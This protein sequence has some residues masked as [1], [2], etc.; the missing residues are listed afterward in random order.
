MLSNPS[1]I[2]VSTAWVL[3]WILHSIQPTSQLL[4]IPITISPWSLPLQFSIS[5][6]TGV[7]QNNGKLDTRGPVSELS[8]TYV[9][10]RWFIL[11]CRVK[12][13]FLLCWDVPSS[14]F[15]SFTIVLKMSWFRIFIIPNIFVSFVSFSVPS[16]TS[17]VPG[18]SLTINRV[19]LQYAV[20]GSTVIPSLVVSSIN[21]VSTVAGISISPLFP[22]TWVS[23]LIPTSIVEPGSVS[24]A[25]VNSSH[26]IQL[27]LSLT[28]LNPGS[29]CNCKYSSNAFKLTNRWI[30]AAISFASRTRSVSTTW[31]LVTLPL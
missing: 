27:Q 5:R 26:C 2:K 19:G 31:Y 24:I 14:L 28:L 10:I 22:S 8:L 21:T 30:V 4:V 18:H 3:T 23:H 15:S 25:D 6:K 13:A 20:F 29:P 9:V 16:S 1:W 17:C 11:A 12:R 7:I